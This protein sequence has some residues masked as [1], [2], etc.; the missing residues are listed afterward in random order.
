MVGT[1]TAERAQAEVSSAI[2]LLR[3]RH[4]LPVTVCYVLALTVVTV[5]WARAEPQAQ[6]RVLAETS[7]NLDNLL[8]GRV[9]TLLSSAFV[10]GDTGTAMTAIP[11]LAC[12]VAL[13]ELRFGALHT[14]WTFLAGH[15]GATLIVAA[16]LWVGVSEHWLPNSTRVAEDVGVSYGTMTLFGSLIVILP[17]PQRIPW[18]LT[19]AVIAAEG[20]W[21]ARDFTS[22]GHLLSYIIGLVIGVRVIARGVWSQRRMNWVDAVFLIAAAALAVSFLLG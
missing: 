14:L 19:W 17:K 21:D 9:S 22:V 15:I 10:I 13:V 7:T 11:L 2:G 3:R 1:L 8:H 4:W 20:V 16:G 18:A 6:D 5:V 12:L